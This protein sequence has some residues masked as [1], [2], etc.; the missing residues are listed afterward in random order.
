VQGDWEGKG[1]D[2]RAH[3]YMMSRGNYT[4]EYRPAQVSAMARIIRRSV[5]SGGFAEVE[6]EEAAQAGRT[7]TADLL[8]GK[9][10]SACRGPGDCVRDD[11]APCT[12][13]GVPPRASNGSRGEDDE[14]KEFAGVAGDFLCGCKTGDSGHCLE[15][16]GRLGEVAPGDVVAS[17]GAFHILQRRPFG[18]EVVKKPFQPAFPGL[19]G[20]SHPVNH[21]K[22]TSRL[23][24]LAQ[25]GKNA[26]LLLGPEV[27]QGEAHEGEVR[28]MFMLEFLEEIG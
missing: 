7:P 1:D 4:D 22:E 26:L 16:L 13:L 24:A 12:R 3:F 6:I 23:E 28:G 27:V 2:F 10:D 21:D 5:G 8:G 20:G 11:S 14:G 9:G 18:I 25:A 19:A 17:Q 15:G